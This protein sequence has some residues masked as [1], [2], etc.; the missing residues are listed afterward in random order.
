MKCLILCV[1]LCSTL[2]PAKLRADLNGDCRVDIADLA[3][4]MSEW[5][6]EEDCDMANLLVSGTISPDVTGVYYKESE[7]NYRKTVG[8]D[9]P[10]IAPDGYNGT[11]FILSYDATFT[12]WWICDTL[13]G[14]YVPGAP[15]Y[16]PPSYATGTAIVTEIQD[17][18]GIPADFMGGQN[19]DEW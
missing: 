15:P 10:C 18:G 16:G 5:L 11:K 1:L 17:G 8:V 7:T 2:S 19:W 13:I 6:Q 4:L 12:R 3:I 14:N 9:F